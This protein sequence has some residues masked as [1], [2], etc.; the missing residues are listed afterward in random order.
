[1]KFINRRMSTVFVA[2][3]MVSTVGMASAK[4]AKVKENATNTELNQRDATGKTVTP[5]DQAQGSNEDV[6]ITRKIRNLI[7]DDESLSVNAHNIKIITLGGTITLRGPVDSVDERLKIMK[8]ATNVAPGKSIRN[9]LEV[10]AA[11]Q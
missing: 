5:V 6:S 2:V 1:M 10:K 11:K 9:E 8:I 4:S 7:T 3:L